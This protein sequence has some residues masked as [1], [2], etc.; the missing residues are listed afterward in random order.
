MGPVLGLGNMVWPPTWW[1]RGG[2]AALRSKAQCEAGKYK[3]FRGD[4]AKTGGNC[5]WSTNNTFIEGEP[6]LERILDI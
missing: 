5:G 4:P 3:Y 1:D 6:T 2:R